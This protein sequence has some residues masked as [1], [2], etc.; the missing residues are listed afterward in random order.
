MG[1]G[2]WGQFPEELAHLSPGEARHGIIR[3]AGING[4][5]K[6]HSEFSENHSQEEHSRFPI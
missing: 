3:Q 2:R 5:E 6:A 4:V 1:G